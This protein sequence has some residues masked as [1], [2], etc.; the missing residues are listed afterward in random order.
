LEEYNLYALSS[1]LHKTVSELQL[2]SIDEIY[3]Y[4]AF[5]EM[6]T[7]KITPKIKKGK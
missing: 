3:G 5:E 4:F 2:L 1:Q 7:N 6:K